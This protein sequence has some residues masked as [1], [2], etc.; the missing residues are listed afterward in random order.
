MTMMGDRGLR[1]AGMCLAAALIVFPQAWEQP[2]HAQE[3]AGDATKPF[4][5]REG[6]QD[7]L[8]LKTKQGKAVAL[9]VAVHT[10]SIDGALGRQAIHLDDFT[11]FRMRGGKIKMVVD[12]KEEVKS[13]DS[14]WTMPAGA[15]F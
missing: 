9:K 7:Q 15:T 10:W 13:A 14:Y 12:G 1:L 2:A 4:R 11:L 6:L 5:V 3:A 8:S